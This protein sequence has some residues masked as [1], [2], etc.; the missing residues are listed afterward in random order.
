MISFIVAN[1]KRQKTATI[2][3]ASIIS[4]FEDI[5]DWAAYVIRIYLLGG[6]VLGT[7][8]AQGETVIF[9]APKE[10][11]ISEAESEASRAGSK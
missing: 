3:I 6:D 5:P 9:I 1:T 10:P 8:A 4:L 2:M 11:A 7:I